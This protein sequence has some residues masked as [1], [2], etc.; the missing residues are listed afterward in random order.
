MFE[1]IFLPEAW[2]ALA[3]LTALEIV[4]GVD[5]II[6][7]SIL[8]G[9]LPEQQRQKAR[10]VGL[11]L[12]MGMRIALLLSIVWVMGLTDPLFSVFEF[13]FSGRDLI[14]FFG[15][16]FLL[17]KSTLE[18]HHSLEGVEEQKTSGKAAT[19]GAIITQIAII[20]IVFSLDSVITAVGLVDYVAVMIIAVIAAVLVMML[21][22]KAIGEFVDSHPTIKMLALS[23]LI[24]IGF[25]LMGEGLG[26]HVPKGYVYFAMAFSLIV[27]LLNIKVRKRNKPVHLKKRVAETQSTTRS[28]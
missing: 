15:G 20:D 10:Q 14:L 6:F 24:L 4:L 13:S 22:A 16:L 7:I 21:A 23:F 28:D 11:L 19:F 12:A 2:V 27:E 5:N 25:T 1:W 9:R 3:T 18:I 26:F 17:G 8:V